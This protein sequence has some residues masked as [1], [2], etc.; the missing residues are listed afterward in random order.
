MKSRLRDFVRINPPIF[1]VSNVGEDPQVFLDGF[2]KVLS[3]MG[4][5][6]WEKEELALYQLREAYQVWYTQWKYNSSI[7]SDSVEYE[8]FMESISC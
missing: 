8:E 3:S 1:L 7:E 6:S 4:V 5:T 2:H